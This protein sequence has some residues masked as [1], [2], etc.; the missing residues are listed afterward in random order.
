LGKCD[1][2]MF[3]CFTCS[4]QMYVKRKRVKGNDLQ[5]LHRKLT[6]EQHE[7]SPKTGE[8]LYTPEGK[9]V[10]AL[11]EKNYF[12]EDETEKWF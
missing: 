12:S 10:P 1:D 4:E 3:Y 11:L 8:N 5:S 9:A 2:K 7:T 6:I